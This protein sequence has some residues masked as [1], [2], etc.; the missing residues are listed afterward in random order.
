[1]IPYSEILAKTAQIRGKAHGESEELNIVVASQI[2][3]GWL[4]EKGLI[5][6]SPEESQ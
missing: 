1:M 5:V 4:R 3:A 6:E 2:L